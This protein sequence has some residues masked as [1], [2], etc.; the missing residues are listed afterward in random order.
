MTDR[1]AG[2][3]ALVTGGGSGIGRATAQALARE[4]A[5]VVVAGRTKGPLAETAG[6]IEKA[7]GRA[8]YAVADVTDSAQ[9]AAAVDAAIAHHGGLHVAVN[10][11]GTLRFGTVA[12]LAE[13]DWR[14]VLD[15]NL[16][17]VWLSMKHQIAH[18]RSHGGG[19]IVNVASNLGAHLRRPGFGAYVAAKA[20]LTALTRNAAL[21]YIGDGVRINAVSPGPSDT[22]MSHRPGE[23]REDRDARLAV[24][25]PI[26][27]AGSLDEITAAILYLAAPESGFVVGHDLVIDGGATA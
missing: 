17:G 7:G 4:G 21:E 3:V 26:G 11:A 23:T 14:A 22:P 27:R 12:D 24:Q 20:G 9:I 6:L 16:T 8:E 25:L 13:D 19:T 18:M 15:T 1:F 2:K 10:N 5:T